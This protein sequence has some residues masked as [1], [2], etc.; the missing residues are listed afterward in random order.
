MPRTPKIQLPQ[1]IVIDQN[2]GG[3]RGERVG[4][5]LPPW[6]LGCEATSWCVELASGRVQ[7]LAGQGALESSSGTE[8]SRNLQYGPS[9]LWLSTSWTELT[10]EVTEKLTI[11]ALKNVLVALCM[12][13]LEIDAFQPGICQKHLVAGYSR[14]YVQLLKRLLKVKY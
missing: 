8:H 5:T 3:D 10:T 13:C 6:G 4:T 11:V 7:L 14:V 12:S 1:Q 9:Y 2:H